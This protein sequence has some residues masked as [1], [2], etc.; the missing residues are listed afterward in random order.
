MINEIIFPGWK[1]S[2]V[3]D[4]GHDRSSD[5]R[6]DGALEKGWNIHDDSVI[7]QEVTRCVLSLIRTVVCSD[8]KAR[9][10]ERQVLKRTHKQMI[11][12]IDQSRDSS[13]SYSS[14]GSNEDQEK[15]KQICWDFVVRG[16]HVCP[17]G[18]GCTLSHV[19]RPVTDLPI[20][21]RTFER[22]DFFP[23]AREVLCLL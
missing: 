10:R 13:F 7:R 3:V 4:W 5:L 6:A 21:H 20:Q 2:A 1:C 12:A 17:R 18:S 11:A 22:E 8:S 15:I 23:I 9:Q 14:T 19:M 16:G